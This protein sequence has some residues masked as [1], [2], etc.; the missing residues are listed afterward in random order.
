MKYCLVV[1]LSSIAA[2]I[3]MMALMKYDEKESFQKY[4]IQVDS[5]QN[6]IPKEA[7]YC[8]KEIEKIFA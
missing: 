2:S 8:D 1:V 4:C 5:L 6:E 7:Y 3:V